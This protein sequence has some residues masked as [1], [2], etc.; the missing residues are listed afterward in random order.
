MSDRL[1]RWGRAL[2][3]VPFGGLRRRHLLAAALLLLVATR[4]FSVRAVVYPDGIALLSNDPYAYRALVDRAVRGG[5]VAVPE[6][7]RVG[8]PLFVAVVAVATA[9]VGDSGVV[10][11]VYPPVVTVASAVAVYAAATRLSDYRAGLAAILWLATVPVHAWR[12]SLGGGDHHAFDYLFLAV[13]MLALVRLLDTRRHEPRTDAATL[14]V[15]VAAQVLAWEAGPLLVAPAALAVGAVP[16][17]DGPDTAARLR[18]VAAGFGLAALLALGAH[19]LLG[20]Q[21]GPIVAVPALV[22]LGTAAVAGLAHLSDRTARPRAAYALGAGLGSAGGGGALWTLWPAFRAEFG[23]GLAFLARSGRWEMAG[24]FADFGPV[25]GPVILLG[26]APL[27]A[28]AGVAVAVHDREHDGWAVVI[29]YALVIGVVAVRHRRFAGEFAVPLAVLSG[30]GFVAGL[31]WL[32]M[33]AASTP[34]DGDRVALP[35]RRALVLGA[36]S[37]A[38][39]APG[40]HFT[41]LVVGEQVVDPRL[42]RAARWI[43]RTAADRGL[44]YP[45]NYVLSE[46]GRNRMFNYFVNGRSLSAGFAADTYLPFLTGGDLQGWYDRLADRVGFVVVRTVPAY[47]SGDGLVSGMPP[48]YRRLHHDLGS[49]AGGFEGTAHFRAVYASPD[50]YVTAFELVAGATLVGRTETAGQITARTTASMP[51]GPTFEFRRTAAVA[52][53]G[54][55]VTVPHPG[56]YRIDG[57]TVR[58]TEADVRAGATVRV[59]S[60]S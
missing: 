15:A 49:A 22:A 2:P 11:A 24:L 14:G 25:F 26:Y 38:A 53:G 5:G 44:T 16:L 31:R 59:D 19:L 30:V 32:G 4:L 46:E 20:W 33:V 10:L 9:L 48:N 58:V 47:E 60:R 37:L 51:A 55:A 3:S 6:T 36:V 17:L 1:R 54:F 35:G 23:S 21:S 43:E 45:E 27:V 12:T 42:Y 40:A 41:R 18:P 29:A 56:R 52:D 8:E 34:E 50:R 39:Y 7:V 28:L 13:T 57:R